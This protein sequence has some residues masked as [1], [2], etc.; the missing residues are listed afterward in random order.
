MIH[1]VLYKSKIY[2]VWIQ[3]MVTLNYGACLVEYPTDLDVFMSSSQAKWI[4]NV[5]LAILPV[6]TFAIDLSLKF[7]GMSGQW[8][9]WHQFHEPF[10]NAIFA[11]VVL[12]VFIRNIFSF[13]RVNPGESGNEILN[14]SYNWYGH[15][16]HVI[17]AVMSALRGVF[18]LFYRQSFRDYFYIFNR[19][20]VAAIEP[21]LLLAFLSVIHLMVILVSHVS[22]DDTEATI[23]YYGSPGRAMWSILVM[24]SSANFPDIMMKSYTSAPLVSIIYII[25]MIF[26]FF[27]VL[28]FLVAVTASTYKSVK[29][30]QHAKNS[31]MRCIVSDATFDLL[32]EA[33]H[34]DDL[35]VNSLHLPRS[36]EADVMVLDHETWVDFVV[37]VKQN[38]LDGYWGANEDRE[39]VE[40]Q[41]RV[42]FRL[43]DGSSDGVM[44]REE[45]RGSMSVLAL[46]LVREAPSW[47]DKLSSDASALASTSFGDWQVRF[48]T[49]VLGPSIR[50]LSLVTVVSHIIVFFHDIFNSVDMYGKRWETNAQWSLPLYD[51]FTGIYTIICFLKIVA[52]ASPD[53]YFNYFM[54]PFHAIE[55]VTIFAGW[56]W[57]WNEIQNQYGWTDHIGTGS[58]STDRVWIQQ[59]WACSIGVR[60]VHLFRFSSAFMKILKVFMKLLPKI[61]PLLGILGI[62]IYGYAILS[63][64]L[65]HH[66]I[67]EVDFNTLPYNSTSFQVNPYWPECSEF[68]GGDLYKQNNFNNVPT[69]FVTLFE[70]L[71]VNN[72]HVIAGGHVC[73]I[74]HYGPRWFFAIFF[75]HMA[76]MGM[77]MVLA[78]ML[79]TYDSTEALVSRNIH[80]SMHTQHYRQMLTRLQE[81]SVWEAQCKHTKSRRDLCNRE[82]INRESINRESI[83][84]ESINRES[85][86]RESMTLG[87][88][89]EEEELQWDETEIE[90]LNWSVKT[91]DFFDMLIMFCYTPEIETIYTFEMDCAE[92]DDSITIRGLESL[93]HTIDSA[94]CHMNE[95]GGMLFMNDAFTKL[96]GVSQTCGTSFEEYKRKAMM[97][98]LRMPHNSML[99]LYEL[100]C[101]VME[102]GDCI[103]EDLD[104]T[105]QQGATSQR[106]NVCAFP[107]ANIG[108]QGLSAVLVLRPWL[109][110]SNISEN[111]GEEEIMKPPPEHPNMGRIICGSTRL[112]ESKTCESVLSLFR[113]SISFQEPAKLGLRYSMASQAPQ[114]MVADGMYERA[115]NGFA[116]SGTESTCRRAVRSKWKKVDTHRVNML[117]SRKER[118]ES[119]FASEGFPLDTVREDTTEFD[120]EAPIDRRKTRDARDVAKEWE[121]RGKPS[122]RH[123]APRG[124][125]FV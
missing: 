72:W 42:M 66:T 76:L 59:V 62:Q 96:I 111:G 20:C 33:T 48:R 13:T 35:R 12:L 15:L 37:A 1:T 84:R 71:V 112:S 9:Y 77:N 67:T 69:A 58:E 3:L 4:G 75:I 121:T 85:I 113:T 80:G 41:A 105:F 27:L 65:Y 51:T 87:S 21:L 38:A 106:Y 88:S 52:Y 54:R 63:V 103:T 86:N 79:D 46:R 29:K 24:I 74:Q 26:A 23:K 11:V 64:E 124:V 50:I 94:V 92:L 57:V 100:R 91:Y 93:L 44:S 118:H 97:K 83:N 18:P 2:H 68:N 117:A 95:D 99:A 122:T 19:S 5:T 119:Q 110:E 73:A 45:F 60:L 25:Y 34:P 109:V 49:F 101:L 90:C 108:S 43:L 115:Q 40:Q 107:F 55:V 47:R 82:S 114:G 10:V 39:H 125:Q 89:V 123:R 78:V 116:E 8:R 61:Y 6:A 102:S 16:G 22:V 53:G 104:L 81:C 17:L 98:Y 70:L 120:A 31:A 36:P 30:H 14:D 32:T 7:Y 56:I 28:N